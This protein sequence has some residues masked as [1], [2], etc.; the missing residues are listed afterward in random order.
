MVNPVVCRRSSSAD[1]FST[2]G[3]AFGG[4]FGGTW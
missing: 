2:F 4:A 3:G 1:G